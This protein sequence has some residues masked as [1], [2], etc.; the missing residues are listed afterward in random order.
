MEIWQALILG[1]VEG[2]TEYL[3][4][5][6]TGH[7]L[8]AQ[9]LL[10][11]EQNEAANAY[12][13]VIQAGAILAVLSLYRSRVIQML[14][15]L[16]GKDP[17][18]LGLALA[19]GVAFLPAAIL[20][21]L[22]DDAIEEILFGPW[23]IAAAWAIGGLFLVI[24][25]TR[26]RGAAGASL[27]GLTLRSALLVGLCQC[28]AMWPG[29]SRSLATILGGL[30]VGLSMSAAVEFSFL[31]G[32]L[33][34]GAAT[35]YKLLGSGA[36]MIASYGPVELAVGFGAAW[37]SA[38]FAVQ[39]MVSWLKERG[40]A[41]FGWWRLGAAALVVGLI[42]NGTLAA[43]APATPA[44]APH[45]SPSPPFPASPT[46]EPPLEPSKDSQGRRPSEIGPLLTATLDPHLKATLSDLEPL[47]YAR[48]PAPAEDL[49]AHVRAASA[50]RR[51][52]P[53]PGEAQGR[54]VILQDDVNAVALRDSTGQVEALL[55][56]KGPGNRR[57]FE[58]ARRNKDL[59]MDLEALTLL[60]DGR[61][62]A[63]GSGSNPHRESVVLLDG[64]RSAVRYS[65][66]FYANLRNESAF[67]GSELN[68]E[69]ALVIQDELWLFQRGN[70]AKGQISK[71]VNAIGRFDLGA[72]LAW[73]DSNATTPRLLHVQPVELGALGTVRF[74]F[75]DA[76][77]TSDGRVAVLACAEASKNAVQDGPVHGCR[78][79]WLSPGSLKMTE[80]VDILGKRAEVKLEGIEALP[81]SGLEFDVVVDPDNPEEPA[82]LGRLTVTES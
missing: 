79:G 57:V 23:P 29:V 4:V 81:G 68:V 63:F 64:E 14:R 40:L 60:P 42:C 69:G 37:L 52:L 2:L 39:W 58:K 17:Q 12:A 72:V 36:A 75:T 82:L 44:L 21:P 9:R 24:S 10:G 66:R 18:G 26:L 25:G 34:L 33:T 46:D 78:F 51:A 5:S 62:L 80:V 59:K 7:L 13:I 38:W 43:A 47:R 65:P 76:A 41:L 27:E 73:L 11:I 54:Q 48:G 16:A 20:G 45:E 22:A 77:S 1:L 30:W 8:I 15:G 31:L 56:P 28:A 50:L 74:S 71:P 6:S 70:G 49:P 19:L 67:S 61:L 32:L 3:P 53:R 55:L 35:A